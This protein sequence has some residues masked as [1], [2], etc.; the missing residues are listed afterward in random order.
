MNT[1]I[2]SDPKRRPVRSRA[3]SIVY[4][5]F[6]LI[7]VALAVDGVFGPHGFI[8]TYRL[9]LEVQQ[10]QR[11][12]QQLKQEN[13]QFTSQVQQLKSDPSAIE[14]VARE[15]MGLVKPGQLVFKLA[16]KSSS[17]AGASSSGKAG[18]TTSSKSSTH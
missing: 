1:R 10:A 17:K 14:R 2:Q 13:H 6:A 18:T 12:T 11:K 5:V 8:A 16:P 9:K 3:D 4:T 15:K 7:L